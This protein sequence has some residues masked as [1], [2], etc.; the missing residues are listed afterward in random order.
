MG[1]HI[2]VTID[3]CGSSCPTDVWVIFL[4]N[5]E[6]VKTTGMYA[7][8]HIRVPV[9]NV[10]VSYAGYARLINILAIFG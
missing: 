10:W 6:F 3:L 2:Y 5:Q 8:P 9:S 4:L 1:Q 7:D